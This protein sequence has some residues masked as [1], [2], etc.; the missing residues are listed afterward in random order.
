MSSPWSR[1]R[2]LLRDGVRALTDPKAAGGRLRPVGRGRSHGSSAPSITIIAH[3]FVN[4]DCGMC[5]DEFLS[6]CSVPSLLIV[7]SPNDGPCLS[8]KKV[9]NI[10]LCPDPPRHTV[11][12]VSPPRASLCGPLPPAVILPLLCI[13]EECRTMRP[14]DRNSQAFT[15]RHYPWT[16]K[17]EP[18]LDFPTQ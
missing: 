10:C 1:L 14:L 15:Y 3:F 7:S 8:F 16:T 4:R 18:N 2:R 12:S 5:S 9:P 6:E 11:R 13:K 17:A